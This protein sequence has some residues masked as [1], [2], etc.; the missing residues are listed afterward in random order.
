MKLGDTGLP[1]IPF[2]ATHEMRMCLP[3]LMTA[4]TALLSCKRRLLSPLLKHLR[5]QLTCSPGCGDA[6]TKDQRE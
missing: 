5:L 2:V 3:L 4:L 6:V 1:K